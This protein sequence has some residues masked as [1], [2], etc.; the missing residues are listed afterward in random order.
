[1]GRVRQKIHAGE[2]MIEFVNYTY[3]SMVMNPKVES[4]EFV[5]KDF[6]ASQY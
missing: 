2:F 3:T 6:D 4:Y 1:M 5:E